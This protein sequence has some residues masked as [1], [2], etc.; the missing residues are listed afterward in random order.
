MFKFTSLLSSEGPHVLRKL[1]KFLYLRQSYRSSI[2]EHIFTH[3]KNVSP[4][5]ILVHA[6]YVTT[7]FYICLYVCTQIVNIL[8]NKL[9]Y[10]YILT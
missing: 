9:T 3:K 1:A 2:L 5:C 8:L 10:I 7:L 4:Y 6:L